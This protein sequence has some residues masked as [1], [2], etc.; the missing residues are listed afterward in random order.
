VSGLI[1]WMIVF[2]VGA[3]IKVFDRCAAASRS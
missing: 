2:G 3:G 1:A